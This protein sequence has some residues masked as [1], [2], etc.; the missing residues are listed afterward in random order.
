MNT[1]FD[2]VEQETLG[3]CRLECRLWVVDNAVHFR[4]KKQQP[5]HKHS[6]FLFVAV[7]L[8]VEI[9]GAEM[10]AVFLIFQR[11]PERDYAVH[12]LIIRLPRQS[13][14]ARNIHTP[15]TCHFSP[16]RKFAGT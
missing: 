1:I 5:R 9:H 7:D 10:A 11:E 16:L 15:H 13:V 8:A 4:E 14:E 3:P 6:G 12:E 2:V